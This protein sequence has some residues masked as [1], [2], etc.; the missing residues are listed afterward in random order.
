MVSINN[1]I[2]VLNTHIRYWFS[3]QYTTAN[4]QFKQ[5]TPEEYQSQKPAD[6][7][8]FDAGFVDSNGI[9]KRF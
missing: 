8:S 2:N 1:K 7:L 3:G 6:N 4:Y 9:I 5:L